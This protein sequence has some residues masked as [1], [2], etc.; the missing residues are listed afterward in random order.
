[1][2]KENVEV[3]RQ[4][5]E[6]L[7]RRDIAAWRDLTDAAFE[8]IDHNPPPDETGT[9]Q[10]RDAVELYLAKW[11]AEFDDFRAHVEEF[12]PIGDRVASAVFWRGTGKGSSAA[13]EWRGADLFTVRDGK[14]VRG[15]SGFTST[16][17]A[18]EA[19]GLLE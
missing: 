12:I 17:A 11:R 19:A 8:F 18:L 13:V 10:G 2:S 14:I 1:M 6:A 15:E 9:F 4:A 16:E 7:N 5:Y 3:V